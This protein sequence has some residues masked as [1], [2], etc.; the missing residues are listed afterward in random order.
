MMQGLGVKKEKNKVRNPD[1]GGPQARTKTGDPAPQSRVKECTH[2]GEPLTFIHNLIA[3]DGSPIE[4]KECLR[5]LGLEIS[6]QHSFQTQI[7]TVIQSG[8]RMAG[9]SLRMFWRKGRYLRLTLLI[10][11]IQPRL[12]YCSLLWFPKYQTSIIR[13]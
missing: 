6:S 4:Q 5:D 13:L 3:P 11:L 10:R 7:D 12:Y 9:W 2:H 8:S 1:E